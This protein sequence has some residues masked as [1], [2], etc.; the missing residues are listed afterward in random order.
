M[1]NYVR[2]TDATDCQ[3]NIR[4]SVICGWM[5]WTVSK[6]FHV[7]EVCGVHKGTDDYACSV[8]KSYAIF[9]LGSTKHPPEK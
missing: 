1:N 8:F 9:L 6:A 4:V 2:S 3:D 5:I 7:L